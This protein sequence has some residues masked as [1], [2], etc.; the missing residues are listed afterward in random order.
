MRS[1]Y[2][3]LAFQMRVLTYI[4][5]LWLVSVNSNGRD[6]GSNAGHYGTISCALTLGHIFL[7]PYALSVWFSSIAQSFWFFVTPWLQLT[8]LP[9]PSL[10]PR[11]CSNS[12][13]L[14]PWCHRNISYFVIPFSSCLQSFPVT[15]SFPMSRLF[16]SSGQSIG[17]SASAS[18]LPVNIQGWFPLGLTGLISLMSKELSRVFSNTTVWKHQFFGT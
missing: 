6:G 14:N 11:V 15:G 12:C 10:T 17:A 5:G 3:F 2:S 9:W 13:P 4:K 16:T 18:V 8:R 1:R 7:A